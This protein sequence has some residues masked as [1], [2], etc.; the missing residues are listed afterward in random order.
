MRVEN[1]RNLSI[2][3][4]KIEKMCHDLSSVLSL[5]LIVVQDAGPSLVEF[6][7]DENRA[8]PEENTRSE[9][10]TCPDDTLA[11]AQS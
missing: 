3:P 8:L 10:Y 11:S 1:R 9:P 4:N 5:S 6:N 7:A 2:A